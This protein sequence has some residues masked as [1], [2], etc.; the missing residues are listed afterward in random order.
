MREGSILLYKFS[1]STNSSGGVVLKVKSPCVSLV[2]R[3]MVA[4]CE[5]ID[6]NSAT[7]ETMESSSS[8]SLSWRHSQKRTPRGY[9][10]RGFTQSARALWKKGLKQSIIYDFP[11]CPCFPESTSLS[12]MGQISRFKIKLLDK[13]AWHRDW[14]FHNS[15]LLKSRCHLAALLKY[16]WI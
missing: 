16:S 15:I 1:R 6:Y 3:T 10:L 7:M 5:N 13:C 8:T 9:S 2:P 4:Y 14:R 12:K 11:V